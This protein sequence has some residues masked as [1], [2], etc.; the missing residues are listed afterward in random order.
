[1]PSYYDVLGVSR[2]ASPEDVRK[3]YRALAL[4]YHPDRAG[5]EGVAKFREIQK[6]YEI[7]SS[8]QKRRIYDKYGEFGLEHDDY[9]FNSTGA[10]ILFVVADFIP[11]LIL[12]LVSM[13]MAFLGTYVDG[14]FRSRD[15]QTVD[16][17][18]RSYWN[19]TKVFIPV[20]I[21][22]AFLLMPIILLAVTA[23]FSCIL[24]VEGTPLRRWVLYLLA[25]KAS[26]V[27]ALSIIVPVVKD[28][29]DEKKLRGETDFYMWC[30]CLIPLY[31]YTSILTSDCIC[32]VVK[33]LQRRQRIRKEKGE[34]F[35]RSATLLSVFRLGN[36]LSLVAFT[37]L[38]ALR[39]DDI[40]TTNYYIVIGLPSLLC[41]I[42]LIMMMLANQMCLS[43]QGKAPVGLCF[44]ACSL[45]YNVL[46]FSIVLAT[47]GM[48][49]KRLNDLVLVE[50]GQQVDVFGLNLAFTPV[51]ILLGIVMLAALAIPCC[52]SFEGPQTGGPRSGTE[53]QRPCRAEENLRGAEEAPV[54]LGS[55]AAET[56]GNMYDDTA[57]AN[58]HVEM[59]R[60]A[61][62]VPVGQVHVSAGL[63]EDGRYKALVDID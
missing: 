42:S 54:E 47:V 3:A 7:L 48:T 25:L 49:C 58:T 22:D 45:I 46:L 18:S 12:S 43:S 52:A 19:Y 53:Q 34:R 39:A 38:I 29:N 63:R 27:I 36:G 55:L 26:L 44:Y 8:T 11:F 62:V 59:L 50:Q 14:G 2:D 9:V 21:L 32:D 31:I 60:K 40:I 1:M 17:T 5:L 41:A 16:D 15:E 23:A 28:A 10:R 6:A 56:T 33:V 13:F 37:V 20:F 35:L 57:G 30:L 51:Y 24:V 61:D 4:Q